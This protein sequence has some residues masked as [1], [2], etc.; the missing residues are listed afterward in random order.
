MGLLKLCL[1]A[2]ALAALTGLVA[3][4][5]AGALSQRGHVFN[6]VSFGVPVADTPLKSP[7]DLAVDE[8]T[9][10]IYVVDS[11]NN[12]IVRFN[13]QHEFLAAWGFGVQ[14][15]KKE[16]E[17]CTSNC[18]AGLAGHAKG[19]FHGAE[20]IAV[21]N[22]T[23]TGDPSRGDV[24]VEAVTPY[25]EEVNGKELEFEYGVIDK[26]TPTG[27]VSG[28]PEPLGQIKGWHEKGGFAEK[29]EAPHGV[30]VGPTGQL[31]IADEEEYLV[32]FDNSEKNKFLHVVESEEKSE[33]R[34]GIALDAKD[35]IYYAHSFE[36]GEEQ[37]VV[38]KE[39][40]FEEEGKLFG[41]TINEAIDQQNTTGLAVAS[42][43]SDVLL[44]HGDSVSVYDSG[45]NLVQVFGKGD[46]ASGQGLAENA[47]NEQ[48]LVADGSKV[49][50]FEA[51]PPGAPLIDE[52]SVFGTEQTVAT[53]GALIDPTGSA[54][55][56]FF[57]YSTEAVP[58]AASACLS[59]CV[60]VPASPAGIG[61]SFGD[62]NVEQHI[63]GLSPS[64]AYHYVVVAENE[65]GGSR[66]VV[67]SRPGAFRTQATLTGS[68]LPDGRVWELV[69]P[70]QKNGAAI[71]GLTGEGGLVEAAADGRSVTYVS[72]GAI[73][74]ISEDGKEIEPEGSRG[75][76]VTQILS[77]R[78]ESGWY[79]SDLDTRHNEAEG[80]TPGSAPEYRAFST[81]LSLGLVEPFG[82]EVVEHPPLSAEA[83]ERTP[84]LRHDETCL[85]NRNDCFQPL[86]T[87]NDVPGGQAFGSK[88][89]F[90][91]GTPDL[92]HAVLAA[93]IPL[94]G[95]KV[96]VRENLY[97]WTPNGPVTAQWPAGSFKLIDVLPNGEPASG[98]FLGYAKGNQLLLRNAVSSDGSRYV[99]STEPG[100]LIPEHLYLR[101]MNAGAEG[102][103]IQ[104]DKVEAGVTQAP[105]RCTENL[106]ECERPH[107]Q[108]AS[109]D[110]SIVFF[111]DEARL[112]PNAG[113]TADKPDLYAC[114]V[115]SSEGRLTGC[116]LTDLTPL[117]SE[118]ANVQGL[119]V[120]ASEDGK[121][122]Y[123]VADA[124]YGGAPAGNCRSDEAG[125]AKSVEGSEARALANTCNL[126]EV[127]LDEATGRW[128]APKYL[129]TLS[130]ED[131]SD[132]LPRGEAADLATLTSR[133][134]PNGQWIA[135][136]SDRSLGSYD[137]RDTIS[138]RN[139]EE[140][141]L[142]DAVD[143]ST[144]CASC[145]PTG[146]RPTGIFD[147]EFAGEGIGLLAD[148]S[149]TW[150]K[151]WLAANIPG[152]VPLELNNSFYQ[153]RYLDD[154]GRLYFNSP[155]ALV[156]ADKNG[157]EDVYQ[158]EPAGVGDCTEQN[159]TF[160]SESNGCVGLI[161]SGTSS[162]ESAFMDASKTGD[163]VF[164]L[165]AE[166]LVQSD[167]DTSYDVYDATVCGI[168]GRPACLLPPEASP[169]RCE[170]T[171]ECSP[172]TTGSQSLTGAASEGASS[173]NDV[174]AQHE[175]LSSKTES[176]PKTTSSKP[177]TR[178]QKLAKALKTCKKDKSKKK[179][180]TCETQAR[181]K[182]GPV[183]K[184]KKSAHS[185]GRRAR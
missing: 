59:P 125:R 91:A 60:Q 96:K 87:T 39:R 99:W 115:Q 174:S 5:P 37:T 44:D 79:S 55:S 144:K 137:T 145:N 66:H 127:A 62:V 74:G 101:D 155:E 134:S 152:Y 35:D 171:S 64:T 130:A 119:V 43:N 14:D 126:Y 68:T 36:A 85:A 90:V 86:L 61:A 21:D 123:F 110:G 121:T 28:K 8:A 77:T 54:T 15:G 170:S 10:D 83:T 151:R 103:T 98:G 124:S 159:Q 104:L 135:F 100:G 140:V 129:D 32:V 132:W 118:S 148:R 138:G 184:A 166:P 109:S 45:G 179:R 12:R 147:Q 143:G 157:K 69:S 122:V 156:A 49:D 164:F 97:E 153:S 46:I 76:E 65:A 50:V 4:T 116:I 17:V 82:S 149:L 133:V 95:E 34:P 161:S 180:H 42:G 67:E 3:T 41:L 113:A 172:G 80:L 52:V 89:R 11:G 178:A 31:W 23:S 173:G 128:S 47:T 70:P 167:R 84:Y 16:F 27:E 48:V 114:Q 7:T 120:G 93:S 165:T 58:P 72:E 150:T 20:T 88:A 182:Y 33:G 154:Q 117:G 139:A 111:T 25:E 160:A 112:T 22:S 81:D 141:Y 57:R 6:G 146:A 106:S 38:G 24:Y 2:C 30:A 18:K 136:M 71:Q 19:E 40:L 63:E 94:S 73:K 1:L 183:K 102:E 175:V 158:Y 56:Y 105:G 26:F 131:E 163:D 168:T 142:Y 92:S 75:P 176:T 177:L 13:A 181:K 169:P 29:F 78:S 185:S 53:L 108:D 107:F 51:E 9:G 162:K